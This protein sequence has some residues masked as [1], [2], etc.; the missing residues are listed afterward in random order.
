MRA[1]ATLLVG[2][3]LLQVAPVALFVAA[4]SSHHACEERGFCPRNPEGPCACR[5]HAHGE[6]AQHGARDAHQGHPERASEA[7][8]EQPSLRACGDLSV[9]GTVTPVQSVKGLVEVPGW[10]PGVRARTRGPLFATHLV[11]QRLADDIFHP[12]RGHVG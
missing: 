11:P 9:P 12:P 4:P 8:D 7:H 10:G 6:H 2:V 1:V 3:L 5:H